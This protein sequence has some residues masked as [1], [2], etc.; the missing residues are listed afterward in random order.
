MYVQEFPNVI[1]TQ[2]FTVLYEIK[3]LHKSHPYYT[4]Y[5]GILDFFF[6]SSWVAYTIYTPLLFF[7]LFFLQA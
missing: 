2:T 6:F 5:Y 1:A 3:F 4:L 7:F